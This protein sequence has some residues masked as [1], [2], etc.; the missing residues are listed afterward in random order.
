MR[1]PYGEYDDRVVA[2][3]KAAGYEKAY[4]VTQG[5]RNEFAEDADY[6]IYSDYVP[7]D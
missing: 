4:S 3:V 7:F 1:Y 6:K 5:V 2:L